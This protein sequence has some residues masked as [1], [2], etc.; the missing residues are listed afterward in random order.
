MAIR[1][2]AMNADGVQ[3]HPVE[4]NATH[5]IR[6]ILPFVLARYVGGRSMLRRPLPED[7]PPFMATR[8]PAEPD[9]YRDERMDWEEQSSVQ[10]LG[11]S[12]LEFP[13]NMEV[14]HACAIQEGI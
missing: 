13:E 5:H 1:L 7:G 4:T 14:E 12:Q 3:V 6:D 11:G 2:L 10:G 8:S 9:P